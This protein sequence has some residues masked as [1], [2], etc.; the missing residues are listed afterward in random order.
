MYVDVKGGAIRILRSGEGQRAAQLPAG[1]S[2]DTAK[3]KERPPPGSRCRF[4]EMVNHA[5]RLVL[6]V[7]PCDCMGR[8]VNF[9]QWEM[10]YGIKA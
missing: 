4:I 1:L 3:G 8:F 10:A 5:R 7:R 9:L 6:V 2:F